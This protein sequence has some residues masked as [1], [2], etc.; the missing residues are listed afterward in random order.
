[1]ILLLAHGRSYYSMGESIGYWIYRRR[2]MRI[3]MGFG[4]IV[5]WAGGEGEWNGG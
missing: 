1:M 3:R 2:G 4:L 5:M